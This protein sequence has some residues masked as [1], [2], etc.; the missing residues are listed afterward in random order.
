M[1][2][3]ISATEKTSLTGAI[4]DSFDTFKRNIDIY[5]EPK[6]VISSISESQLFGYGT[7]SNIVNYTF[8]TVSGTYSATIRYLNDKE[9]EVNQ[10]INTRIPDGKV[11]IK[12]QSDARNFIEDGKTEKV[13]FDGKSFNVVSEDIVKSFL[14]AEYYVYYLEVSK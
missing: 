7:S 9:G 10:D 3:L 12:V 4:A 6:R 2:S 14:G 11:R 5:K 13:V 8:Q 1:A